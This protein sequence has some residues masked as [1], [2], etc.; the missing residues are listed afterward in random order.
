MKLPLIRHGF[1]TLLMSVFLLSISSAVSAQGLIP[2]PPLTR[3]VTDLNGTLPIPE[4]DALE[5]RLRSFEAQKG[6]QVVVLVL[7]SVLPEE[8][9]QFGIRVAEAWKI[10]RTKVDDGVILIVATGDRRVRI[11]VGYGLEGAL[12]DFTAKRIIEEIILPEFR[13]GNVPLGI[14]QGVDAILAVIQ[15]E[16]LPPP[17]AQSSNLG[18]NSDLLFGGVMALVAIGPL[19]KAMLG[20]RNGSM[21]AGFI[22]FCLAL[23]VVP[24]L[25]AIIFGFA[26]ALLTLANS[27]GGSG[28]GFRSGG[29]RS[30]GGFSGG[31]GG[32]GGGGAS[33]RW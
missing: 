2:V 5:Q 15:G 24:L 33:G 4:R 29:G 22:V 21:L 17:R 6:S 10:G 1:L 32:F 13:S 28:G 18:E 8:I 14:S 25:L 19:F 3:P 11:E 30:S 20:K 9:E 12:P 7:D 23:F 27:G 16:E 26:A 31:G